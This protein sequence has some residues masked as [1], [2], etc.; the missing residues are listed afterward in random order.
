MYSEEYS[1][2]EETALVTSEWTDNWIE[3][4]KEAVNE[5]SLCWLVSNSVSS[6]R[7]SAVR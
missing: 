2:W 5:V 3:R 7:F 4:W 6:V 1:K